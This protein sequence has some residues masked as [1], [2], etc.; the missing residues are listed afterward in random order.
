LVNFS[1]NTNLIGDVMVIM[2]ASIEVEQGLILDMIK[3]S[4]IN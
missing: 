4:T 1:E 3:Q 2:I